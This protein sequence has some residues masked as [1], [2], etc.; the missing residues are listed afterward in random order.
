MC[1]L[2]ALVV[3]PGGDCD[4]I[5]F[6]DGVCDAIDRGHGFGYWLALL[7]TIAGTALAAVRRSAD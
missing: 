7:A 2:L 5:A 6:M 3:T 4:D 1:T